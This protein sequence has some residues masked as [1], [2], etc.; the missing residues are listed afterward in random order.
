MAARLREQIELGTVIAERELLFQRPGEVARPVCVRIGTPVEDTKHPGNALCPMQVSGFE[1]DEKM[2]IGGVDTLQ[3]LVLALQSAAAFVTACARERG[4][5][6]TWL[7]GNDLGFPE[8]SSSS[9]AP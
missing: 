6:L 9:K 8:S 4:G 3:A 5:T 1:K 2:V 7:G